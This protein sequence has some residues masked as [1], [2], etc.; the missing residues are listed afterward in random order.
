[1]IEKERKFILKYMPENVCKTSSTIKQGYLMIDENQHLRIRIVNDHTAYICYKTGIGMIRNEYEYEIP[2]ADGFELYE[3]AE[4]KI[5]KNRHHIYDTNGKECMILD[6]DEYKDGKAV[7]EIEF[8]NEL[9][10]IPDY[11]G[12][13]VTGIKEW[14]NIW[15]ATNNVILQK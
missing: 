6:I 4:Y 12:D 3:S 2:I 5:E 11:C 15:L 7:V 14:S 1:M 10:Y 13:E 8:E 9:T